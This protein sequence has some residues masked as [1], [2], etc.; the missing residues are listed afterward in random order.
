MCPSTTHAHIRTRDPIQEGERGV[1]G[2]RGELPQRRQAG[3]QLAAGPGGKQQHGRGRQEKAAAG[4]HGVVAT[5]W[6]DG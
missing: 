2:R 4:G 6:G 3:L 1:V 5:V